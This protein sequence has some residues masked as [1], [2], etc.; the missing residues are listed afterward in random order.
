MYPGRTLGIVLA[1]LCI[2]KVPRGVFGGCKEFSLWYG[3]HTYVELKITRNHFNKMYLI[4]EPVVVQDLIVRRCLITLAVR[5]RHGSG[6]Q[7]DRDERGDVHDGIA[8]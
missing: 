8:S 2:G 3:F 4:S 6:Y 1:V 5:L 7:H